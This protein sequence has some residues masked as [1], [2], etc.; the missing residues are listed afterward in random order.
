M[1]IWG[2]LP[3]IHME[4]VSKVRLR[5]H[6]KVVARLVRIGTKVMGRTKQMLSRRAL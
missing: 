3:G 2:Q 6:Y 1:H 5:S 4:R